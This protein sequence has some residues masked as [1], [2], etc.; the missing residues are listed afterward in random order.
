MNI[1]R[2]TAIKASAATVAAMSLPA[3][4]APV[5]AGPILIPRKVISDARLKSFHFEWD[6]T[7][8]IGDTIKEKCETLS[9]LITRL[10]LLAG[11]FTSHGFHYIVGGPEAVCLLEVCSSMYCKFEPV[12]SGHWVD[13]IVA[14]VE[15]KAIPVCGYVSGHPYPQFDIDELYDDKPID[16][17][18]PIC[19]NH[20]FGLLKDYL[21]PVSEILLANE[22]FTYAV[23]IKM[24]N[25]LL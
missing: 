17:G 7:T 9:Q 19:P 24:N 5:K 15:Q 4:A 20:R 11:G 6:F 13:P 25:Y 23:K 14:S 21:Y 22:S 2:R 12:S 10:S 18:P 1:S 8:C 16:K 3:I